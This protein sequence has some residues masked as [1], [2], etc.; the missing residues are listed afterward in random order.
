MHDLTAFQRDTLYVIAA[1]ESNDDDDDDDDD[2]QPYGLAIK[3]GLE[4][5]YGIGVNHGRLYPNLDKL[6]EADLVEKSK[7]DKRTNAYELTDRAYRAM[8]QRRDWEDEQ[9][10]L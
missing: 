10:E 3:R 9:A 8:E 7:I 1:I 6:E 4:E 5:Y 2:Q